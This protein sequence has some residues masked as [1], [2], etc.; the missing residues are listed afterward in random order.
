MALG[1]GISSGS[2]V[3]TDALSS[4]NSL[5]SDCS[6][7]GGTPTNS[8]SR[9]HLGWTNKVMR[10]PGLPALPESPS[11][12]RPHMSLVRMVLALLQPGPNQCGSE[13]S[14]HGKL[15]EASVTRRRVNRIR[16]PNKIEPYPSPPLLF[17]DLNKLADVIPHLR[18]ARENHANQ[19][20]PVFPF[21]EL[22]PASESQAPSLASHSQAAEN[23]QI[24]VSLPGKSLLHFG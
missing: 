6:A 5:K 16:P 18:N 15:P 22:C 2:R 13:I 12:I 17:L 11:L 20:F 14:N 23:D 4:I 21:Q 1:S 3:L 19:S 8:R 24:W 10:H 9:Y 7:S